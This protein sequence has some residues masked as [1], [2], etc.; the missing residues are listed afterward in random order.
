MNW[1]GQSNAVLDLVIAAGAVIVMLYGLLRFLNRSLESKIIR[2][3][4]E[5]T[6]QIQPNANGGKSLS[7]LHK[8]I[9]A[10]MDDI[11]ELKEG[12][13]RLER[14]IDKVEKELDEFHVD[15]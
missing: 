3:I 10:M 12:H 11:C 6:T 2:E 8:K 5:A 13:A 14:E 1:L 9:D 7:D 4:K 15:E